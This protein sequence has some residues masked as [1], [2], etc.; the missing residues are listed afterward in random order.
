MLKGWR[1]VATRSDRCAH[2]FMAAIRIA[3]NVIFPIVHRVLTLDIC[4]AGGIYR[5]L[6]AIPSDRCVRAGTMDV[7]LDVKSDFK[8]FRSTCGLGL[9]ACRDFKKND[10]IIEYTG[11]KISNDEAS[12]K[13]NRYLFGLDDQWMIDGSPRTNLARYINHSCAPNA[14]AVHDEEENRIFIE[15]IRK[16][17]AGEEITYDYGNEHFEEYIKPAGC[18]CSKCLDGKSRTPARKKPKNTA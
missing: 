14:Q 3:A 1:R 16:I 17:K 10:T 8:V 2:T 18:K 13:P 7:S 5:A 12:E 11:P 15:A 9:R 4:K 6:P